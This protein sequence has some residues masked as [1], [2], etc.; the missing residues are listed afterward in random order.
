ME[1]SFIITGAIREYI[2][3]KTGLTKTLT[4]GLRKIAQRVQIRQSF[5]I[6]RLVHDINQALD[7]IL[8]HDVLADLL[9]ARR[10]PSNELDGL[11]YLLYYT[12]SRFR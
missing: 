3:T 1:W 8:L 11:V 7:V 5:Q 6:F 10:C 2:D 12:Q 9:L 4:D